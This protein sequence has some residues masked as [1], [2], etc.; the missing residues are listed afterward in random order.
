MKQIRILWTDD[1]IDL[2]KPHIIFLQNKGYEVST[3]NNGD[4]AIELVRE[5]NFDLV[6]LDENMPG[7]S[8]LETLK[9]IKGEFPS[10]PVVMITK[11]EEED[12]MEA[13]IGSHIADYLIK[14]VNPN[15]I[16]LS[17]KKN[18][19]QKTLVT[20]KTTSDYQQ[21]FSR[22]GMQINDSFSWEDWINLH[23]KLTYW[24]LELEKSNDNTMD[25][26]LL[27][28]KN[29]ANSA[30]SKFIK[31]QY[32]TWFDKNS[33]KAP[34]MSHTVFRKKVFPLLNEKKPVVVI[35]IDNLRF[36]QW[37]TIQPVIR[38]YY[39]LKEESLFYSIL[40]TATQYARNS[41]FAGLMP[42]EIAKIYP[43][44]WL[45]DEDEGNKNDYEKEL[46]ERQLGRY[47]LN[48]DFA[49]EKIKQNK[50]S[51][52]IF[53]NLKTLLK[54][55]LSVFVFNFVDMLSHSRTE[56]QMIRELAEDESAY[57]SL[58]LS[59]FNHSPLLELFKELA[60][61]DVQVV[62][63]TDH[64]MVK[65]HDPLKVIGDRNTTTNLRYKQGRSLNYNPKDVFE[66]TDPGK[67]HLPKTNISTTYIFAT[68]S[69]FFAYPNNYN[70]Y[71][72]YYQ[73]TFQH[74]G[75]SL[76]EMLVPFIVLNP[77]GV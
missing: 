74:G 70:H 59:W 8:G 71:V 34:I 54:K 2:L 43:Q 67:V 28:Q 60:K 72:K 4:D 14:P 77:K 12:I 69:D 46:L 57:R 9:V 36:D 75:V 48:I 20:R 30:F 52:R 45:N 16:L 18:I 56:M 51:K 44:V 61:E 29:E 55:E 47:N 37:K 3:A 10:L 7:K 11:S 6:F 27:M 49:Y 50:E 31:K 38:E 19:D 13:A 68:G 40:P 32:E 15:Q 73:D 33:D 65:V 63:T 23:K 5:N 21:E 66:V 1:E 41:M 58:T 76:E 24:E 22:I 42:A 53:D 17:I 64:G 39:H 35:L 62:I 26:V 25:E